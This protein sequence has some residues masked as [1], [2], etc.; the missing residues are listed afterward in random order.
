MLWS[1][2][3]FGGLV[4]RKRCRVMVGTCVRFLG[5]S[6]Q[7]QGESHDSERLTRLLAAYVTHITC[8]R[9]DLGG[10]FYSPTTS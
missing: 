8:A 10:P 6:R 5:S 2:V 7:D 3:L 1:D 4:D 9:P